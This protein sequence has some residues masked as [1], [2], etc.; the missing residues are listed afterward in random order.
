MMLTQLA[1]V[2]RAA[3]LVVIEEPGWKQ[4]GHG[5]M[6]DVLGVTCHHTAN[7]G[8]KGVEPSRTVVR[9]GRPGLK[10]PLAQLLLRK[11]GVYRVIAAGLCYHAGV[12]KAPQYGNAH[13]IGIEAEAKGV[14]G[15]V[16]DWPTVQMNAY[17]R[18]CK[19]LMAHYGF[20]VSQVLGHKET[21]APP[22]RKSDP[23]F[24]MNRFR[25]NT[26]AVILHPKPATSTKP[27]AVED[28]MASKAELEALILDIFRN[29]P[30]VKNLPT[31]PGGPIGGDLS[32]TQVLAYSDL[33]ADQANDKIN[34]VL[35]RQKSIESKLDAVLAAL[36]PKTP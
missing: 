30:L 15:T 11:D 12:S 33:K 32:L 23:D 31:I 3:G 14:P 29:R 20:S 10:G 18:G 24:D 1:D 25:I 4:R 36:V 2:L 26:S 21:C 19:A 5:A 27:A 13:R 6:V 22:G 16:G 34:G 7:G 28:I 8:A 9:D 35:E 17:H